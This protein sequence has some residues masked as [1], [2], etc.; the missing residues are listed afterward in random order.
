MPV[1]IGILMDHPSPHMVAL[2]EAIAERSDCTLEVLYCGQ[3]APGRGWGA[4]AG[5]IPHQFVGGFTGPL[6]IRINPGIIRAMHR[7]HIDVWIMNTVYGSPTTLMAARWLHFHDKPWV[8]MNEPVRPRAG[9]HAFLKELPLH[10][11][12]NAAD[13]IIGTGKAA[14]DMYHRRLRRN[15][16]SES[17]PYFIDI[18][19]FL[20]LPDPT[21]PADGRD[22]QFVSSGQLIKRKG[23]DFLLQACKKLP[24]TGWHLTLIGDGPLRSK[25]EKTLE[26]YGLVGKVSIHGTVPYSQRA[27]SFADRQ[28]FLFPSLWDGWGMVVPEALASGLP[29]VSTDSVMSA[30]EFIRNGENGFIIPA[31]DSGALADKMLWFLRNTSSYRYMSRAARKSVDNYR[32]E[33]G[34]DR[35]VRFLQRFVKSPATT[36]FTEYAFQKPEELTWHFLTTPARAIERSK[37]RIRRIVKKSIIRSSVLARRPR[38]A[39]GHSILAYHLVL[40]ED[41]RNFEDQLKFFSDH[42]SISPLRE[43]IQTAAS[44][45][46]DE[47]RLAITFDDGFRLLMHDCLEMLEKYGVKAGFYIPAAF[48]G[49]KLQNGSTD[50]FSARSFYYSYPLEPMGP[51]DLKQ[52]AALGHEVGSHGLFHT[53]IHS[54]TPESAERELTL[55]RSMISDWIGVAPEGYA[56]PYGGTANA[57]GNP[58]DWLNKAGFA[59]GLTLTRGTVDSSTNRFVLPRHHAEGNWPVCD[60][61][62]FLF[63]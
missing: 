12:L 47:R 61:R 11:V 34:A 36:Q 37:H 51:E 21:A 58:A 38:K 52:L 31:G 23:F 3:S 62:Y 45:D 60:L 35:L 13:G 41:R 29:V 57:R 50:E 32:A 14:I 24:E 53:N 33:I 56:Y 22:F 10:F 18:S 48:I 55:S 63:A 2:L 28:V 1:R 5:R 16:P 7:L 25:L 19:E 20:N 42:F 8:Y 54:L 4:P 9:I 17:I 26:T 46:S 59:Y 27:R 30:H 40:K 6:G 44:G 15:L 39:K 49:S 43:L